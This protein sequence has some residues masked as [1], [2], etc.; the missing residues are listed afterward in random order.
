M[1]TSIRAS[2]TQYNQH[3]VLRSGLGPQEVWN[4]I[5]SE[6]DVCLPCS[7]SLVIGWLC[8]SGAPASLSRQCCTAGYTLDGPAYQAALAAYDPD[9]NGRLELTEFIAFSLFL[10]CAAD[11]FKAFD[12]QRSGTVSL[13]LNQFIYAAAN[14]R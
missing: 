1:L 4:A 12:F 7:P 11:S 13:S 3:N 10:R 8:A 14:C 9:R 5:Q 2:Q 6:G